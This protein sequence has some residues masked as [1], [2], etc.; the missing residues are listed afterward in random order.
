MKTLWK[1]GFLFGSVVVTISIVIFVQQLPA[2]GERNME[3]TDALNR[4]EIPPIDRKIP[5]QVET[6]TF[7]LG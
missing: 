4:T 2:R 5:A 6:A 1:T 7:A 3:G